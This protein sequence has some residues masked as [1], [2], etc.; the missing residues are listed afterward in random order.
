MAAAG[1]SDA[2]ST[3]KAALS[4]AKSFS[5]SVDPSGSTAKKATPNT[6]APAAAA[7][8]SAPTISDE[9][10]AKQAN[11][12]EYS[13]SLPKM[14]TGG[15]ITKDGDYKL[16]AG[17]KVI[18]ASGRQSEYRKVFIQRQQRD[19]GGNQP[20]SASKEEHVKGAEQVKDPAGA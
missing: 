9:L 17:E 7:Q 10:K 8:K 19:K 14:H 3:A 1:P 16:L 13:A 18:P 12:N 11:I 6:A 5:K 2:I 20:V 15:D 4:G